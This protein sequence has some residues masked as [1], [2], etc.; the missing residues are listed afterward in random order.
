MMPF[1]CYLTQTSCKK[2]CTNHL[3][4][5]THRHRSILRS[6]ARDSEGA[7]CRRAVCWVQVQVTAS[8]GRGRSHGLLPALLQE[9]LR[10][11]SALHSHFT[12]HAEYCFTSC[13]IQSYKI[14][15]V[16]LKRAQPTI[17]FIGCFQDALSL[18]LL[19]ASN[20]TQSNPMD[21]CALSVPCFSRCRQWQR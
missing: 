21:Y 18:F 20:P 6:G 19:I 11:L 12:S 8:G 1:H 3:Y 9:A 5:C 7:R 4:Y 14:E 13:N 10:Y 2:H 16:T 15:L 17:P